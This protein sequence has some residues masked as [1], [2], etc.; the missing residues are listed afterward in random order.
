MDILGIFQ[1][2][3]FEL[4]LYTWEKVIEDRLTYQSLKK[5]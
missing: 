3:F 1:E 5:I 2:L 4:E